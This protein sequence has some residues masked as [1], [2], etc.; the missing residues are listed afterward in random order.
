MLLEYYKHYNFIQ[1]YRSIDTRE[2]GDLNSRLFE[3]NVSITA[4]IYFII[5]VYLFEK[6]WCR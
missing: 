5:S 3:K 6:Y 1:S 2:S 4:C